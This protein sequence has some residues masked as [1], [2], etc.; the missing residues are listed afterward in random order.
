MTTAGHCWC[1]HTESEHDDYSCHECQKEKTLDEGY[2]H[3]PSHQYFQIS[4]PAI[5]P[6]PKEHSEK[7][8]S[9]TTKVPRRE[10]IEKTTRY[11]P[12]KPTPSTLGEKESEGFN[13]GPWLVIGL[14]VLLMVLNATLVQFRTILSYVLGIGLIIVFLWFRNGNGFV[15]SKCKTENLPEARFCQSCG[16]VL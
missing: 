12:P 2:P 5:E 3:V 8:D 15:C 10:S 4:V 7:Q 13:Y 11:S 16:Q 6:S 9:S 14:I 1:R